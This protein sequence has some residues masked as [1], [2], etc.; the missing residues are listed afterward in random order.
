MHRAVT[1]AR[2]QGIFPFCLTIDREA[3]NYLPRGLR[4]ELD[5]AAGGRA[6]ALEIAGCPEKS[7]AFDHVAAAEFQV[8]AVVEISDGE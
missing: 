7:A 4:R 8:L 2:L 5:A 3:A 6:A 1:E